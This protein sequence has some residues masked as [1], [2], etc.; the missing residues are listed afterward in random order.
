[1]KNQNEFLNEFEIKKY[2][3][4]PILLYFVLEKSLLIKKKEKIDNLFFFKKFFLFESLSESK[5]QRIIE[6]K[7]TLNF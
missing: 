2:K 3:N 6:I 5:E 7:V 4:I 1:M